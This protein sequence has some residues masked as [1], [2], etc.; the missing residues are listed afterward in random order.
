MNKPFYVKNGDELVD[1]DGDS[2]VV[3]EIADSSRWVKLKFKTGRELWA[4]TRNCK[5][6]MPVKILKSELAKI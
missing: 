2:G 6:A 3:I 5:K 1:A 4:M